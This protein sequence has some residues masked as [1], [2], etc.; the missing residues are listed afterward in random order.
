MNVNKMF[1]PWKYVDHDEI[2]SIERSTVVGEVKVSE[3][4]TSYL[5]VAIGVTVSSLK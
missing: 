1:D 2:L 3:T 4:I 5:D